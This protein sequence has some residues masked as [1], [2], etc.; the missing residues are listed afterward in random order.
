M[1]FKDFINKINLE[2]NYQLKNPLEKDPECLIGL[3]RDELEALAESVLSTSQQEQLNSLL[4]QNS[5]GQLSAQE[6]IVLDVILSQ[7]DKLTILRTRARYTL[8]K[9]D[10][11][12]P[13]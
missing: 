3:S 10:A 7:V 12:L 1:L 2:T 6:T 4:I 8:K 11:L 13:V 9:M 5:E